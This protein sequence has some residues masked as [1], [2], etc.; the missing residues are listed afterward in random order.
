MRDRRRYV[1]AP[2]GTEW[3]LRVTRGYRPVET[4][5]T[6]SGG[7]GILSQAGAML[8]AV[9]DGVLWLGARAADGIVRAAA[10]LAHRPHD[11][12]TDLYVV[13]AATTWPHPETYRWVVREADLD[14]VFG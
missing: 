9:A 14:A 6:A 5:D 7:A 11:D 8:G 4:R 1:R 13:A 12:G 2:D 3:E 10:Q